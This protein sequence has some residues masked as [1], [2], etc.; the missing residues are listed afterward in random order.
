MA[1]LHKGTTAGTIGLKMAWKKQVESEQERW[2]NLCEAWVPQLVTNTLNSHANKQNLPIQNTSVTKV[3]CIVTIV[4]VTETVQARL[5]CPTNCDNFL[6]HLPHA[7]AVQSQSFPSFF[8]YTRFF[9]FLSLWSLSK[10]LCPIRAAAADTSVLP[11]F[12]CAWCSFP[13]PFVV[14][15]VHPAYKLKYVFDW[16]Y[17]LHLLGPLGQHHLSIYSLTSNTIYLES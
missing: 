13:H 7:S 12:V 4:L 3:P 9:L 1:H 2:G 16:S 15:P 10:R 11:C 14:Q 5:C 8:S 6:S 17:T